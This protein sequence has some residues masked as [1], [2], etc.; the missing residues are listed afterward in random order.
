M[1]KR[2]LLEVFVLAVVWGGI[3]TASG[4]QASGGKPAQNER[5]RPKFYVIRVVSE[6]NVKDANA[7]LGA[8]DGRYSE[9]APGGRM[10]LQMEKKIYPSTTFDDGLVVCKGEASFGL[11]GWFPVTSDQGKSDFAWMPLLR[12]QSSGGFRVAHV[13]EIGGNAGVDLIRIANAGTKPLFVDA[14]IGYGR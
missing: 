9:I 8:P 12:G 5:D 14:I 2:S 3:I 13:D 6:E 4:L 7:V 1:T 11:E 10:V